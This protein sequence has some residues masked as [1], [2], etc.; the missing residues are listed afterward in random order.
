MHAHSVTKQVSMPRPRAAVCDALWAASWL[1]TCPGLGSW[2]AI[3]LPQ[4]VVYV[5]SYAGCKFMSA[6]PKELAV[7][8][9]AGQMIC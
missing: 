5:W 9:C 6:A 7:M 3:P 2:A 4:Q 8:Y 1:V